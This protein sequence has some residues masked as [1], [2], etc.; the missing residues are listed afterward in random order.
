MKKLNQS[1]RIN[2]CKNSTSSRFILTDRNLKTHCRSISNEMTEN[3]AFF[4]NRV[5]NS[6]VY[7]Q[8]ELAKVNQELDSFEIAKL[9][10]AGMKESFCGYL[11]Y[12]EGL[13]L[14]LKGRDSLTSNCL[15]RAIV[16]LRKSLKTLQAVKEET[17]KEPR[18]AARPTRENLTQTYEAET[19]EDPDPYTNEILYIKNIVAKAG[20]LRSGK[21]MQKLVDLHEDLSKLYTDL[22]TPTETP[23]PAEINI[24]SMGQKLGITLKLIKAEI[25]ENLNKIKI[26]TKKESKSTQVE[27]NKPSNFIDPV[28]EKEN[29]IL[30]L[31]RT[32]EHYQQKNKE[33]SESLAKFKAYSSEIETKHNEVKIELIQTR[34]K[35]QLAE[36]T[37][38]SC[39]LKINQVVEKHLSKSRKLQETRQELSNVKQESILAH[40][41]LKQIKSELVSMTVISKLTEEKLVQIDSAWSHSMGSKFVFEKVSSIEVAKKYNIYNSED[42][43]DENVKSPRLAKRGHFVSSPRLPGRSPVDRSIKEDPRM[44]QTGVIKPLVLR[45]LKFVAHI[46][47]SPQTIPQI[48]LIIEAPLFKHEPGHNDYLHSKDPKDQLDFRDYRDSKDGLDLNDHFRHKTLPIIIESQPG[49]HDKISKFTEALNFFESSHDSSKEQISFKPQRQTPRFH[50]RKPSNIR[51]NLIRETNELSSSSGPGSPTNTRPRA[52]VTSLVYENEII[53]NKAKVET[54]KLKNVEEN[55]K[56]IQYILPEVPE[57]KIK[58]RFTRAD[59]LRVKQRPDPDAFDEETLENLRNMCEK[60]GLEGF[61]SFPSN[62]KLE[63]FKSLEGHDMK[64]C[65]GE[66]IHLK[67]LANIKYRTRGVPYPIK[68]ST[69]TTKF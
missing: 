52:I 21:I 60:Y 4:V 3:S 33:T 69:L 17:V 38:K 29:E 59:T 55:S 49:N 39:K 22:P 40:Q 19:K 51:T 11:R 25:N 8:Q 24:G 58:P 28:K 64:R 12:L 35:L 5:K 68:T 34:N 41:S 13:S 27:S 30:N 50:S 31:K 56:A 36:D 57:T 66:C 7:Y 15:I 65:E 43:F 23:E 63:L 53:H 42:S 18:V 37:V 54:D 44:S 16:G 10:G 14:A 62:L 61:E 1:F 46:E 48:P 45:D 26:N 32:L 2:S 9:Q 47:Q 6:A 67:R 20:K